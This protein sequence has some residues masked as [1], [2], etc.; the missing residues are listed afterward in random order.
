MTANAT[1]SST[2]VP[3][4]SRYSPNPNAIPMAATD[5]MPAAVVR[6][7]TRSLTWMIV[8][9]PRKPMPVTIWA[10][11]RDTASSLPSNA[12]SP[13]SVNRQAPMATTAK[14]RTPAGLSWRLAFQPEDAAGRRGEDEPEER[15]ELGFERHVRQ[16]GVARGHG[17]TCAPASNGLRR[18]DSRPVPGIGAKLDT[19]RLH[20]CAAVS[21]IDAT[22]RPVGRSHRTGVAP[23]PG[24]PSPMPK[25]DPTEQSRSR[26]ERI[27][28][29]AFHAFSTRGY[30]DTAVDDIAGAAETSK[31]G[32]LL[33][34]PDQGS[35][36][37]AS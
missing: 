32:D 1:S 27:L 18:G 4:P 7:S 3:I 21:T 22:D 26:R 5:Q 14:V 15:V 6:P 37:S 12:S 13:T 17:C 33:P 31:G 25:P 36:S 30:R 16:G 8:P 35:R 11:R 28:D 23:Q 20:V 9:A 2:V 29:A 34:L 24:P 10:T 19:R